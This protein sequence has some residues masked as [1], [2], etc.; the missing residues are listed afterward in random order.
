MLPSR[1][2]IHNRTPD[3]RVVP[4]WLETRDEP[5]L[6][7]LVAEASALSGRRA[8]EVDERLIEQV[9]RSA[10]SH[11]V[12]RR[13]VEAVWAVERKRWKMRVDAPVAPATIRRTLFPLACTHPREEAISSAAALLK[14]KADRIE[15]W[16]FADRAAARFLVAPASA[17]TTH[18]LIEGYN[19]A[20]VQALLHRATDIR[21]TARTYLKRVVGYAKLLGL[22]LVF[23][24]A[25][26]GATVMSLSGPLALFHDTIKY[27]HALAR[28]V[29]TLVTTAG[30]SLSANL[31]LAGEKLRFELD[32][33]APLPRTHAM[34]KP[35]DSQLEARLDRDLRACA[36]RWH[37]E[38][39]TAVLQICDVDGIRRLVFP[40]FA[41]TSDEHRVLVE[42]VG[43]WTPEYLA[44][45]LP[46]LERTTE[47]L[48]L[49]IDEKHIVHLEVPRF[50][51]SR[52]VTFKKRI[53]V[54]KLLAA[55]E[56]VAGVRGAA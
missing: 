8:R 44:R 39:E 11:G 33:G 15:E 48:I 45:K 29:P 1:L 7:E 22:M 54:T 52:I 49:C 5:W 24:Q 38:R 10:R 21:A 40:D 14:I 6:R 3:G 12:S 13:L 25:N 55:V 26:D 18:D 47:P 53:D 31:L 4:R 42:V 34:S 36:S 27:G 35:H 43:Y 56:R 32:A 50:I 51:G 37:I 20:L 41:V 16:L 30:W 28:W 17:A 46:L 9:A 23:E 19:L 2:L